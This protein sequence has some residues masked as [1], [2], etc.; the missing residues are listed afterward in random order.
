MND[1]HVGHGRVAPGRHTA[2]P[3]SRDAR[4]SRWLVA[5][6][7]LAP[8]VGFALAEGPLNLGAGGEW[9]LWKAATIGILVA[10]PFGF[11]AF[12]GIRAVRQGRRE[13]WL[14]AIANVALA[15]LAVSTPIVE[16]TNA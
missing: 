10:I 13:G 16:A 4:L 15:A 1:I 11:G 7:A 9:E 2:A 3:G 8:L 5:W 14:G 6:I 12:F